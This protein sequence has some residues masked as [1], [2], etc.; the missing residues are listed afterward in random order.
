MD[1]E[2]APSVLVGIDAIK[3]AIK[4]VIELLDSEIAAFKDRLALP[5]VDPE[6]AF[7][8][9]RALSEENERFTAKERLTVPKPP[10]ERL[11]QPRIL[12]GG[13]THSHGC[14]RH[15]AWHEIGEHP[16]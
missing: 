10:F 14:W 5:V 1:E 3:S 7:R 13:D 6:Q 11:L 2:D 12:E 4:P 15:F 8:Q 9:L 16:I